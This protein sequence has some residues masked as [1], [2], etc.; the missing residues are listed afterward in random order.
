MTNKEKFIANMKD[1]LYNINFVNELADKLDKIS[2]FTVPASINYHGN[3]EGGLYDHSWEVTRQL[4]YLTKRLDLTWN[5]PESPYIVGMLH[6]LCKCDDYKKSCSRRPN[7]ISMGLGNDDGCY[8]EKWEYN[9][10]GLL[11]GHGE[12]SVIMAQNIYGYLTEEEIMCIRWHMGAFDDKSNW[13]YYS[14][15]VAKYPN[16]LFTH[17]ADMIASQISTI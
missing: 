1:N 13:Q 3:Y 16:V 15:A 8:E 7:A 10:N 9:K 2:F 17:T 5:R 11:P 4:L 12:K 6:D 14:G